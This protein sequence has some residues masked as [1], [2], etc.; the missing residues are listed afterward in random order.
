MTLQGI[1]AEIG[2]RLHGLAYAIEVCNECRLSCPTCPQGIGERYKEMM[3]VDMFMQVLERALSQSKIRELMLYKWGDPLLHPDLDTLCRE[4]VHRGVLTKLSTT[5]NNIDCDLKK[6][7]L[8]GVSTFFVSFSGWDHYGLGHRGGN[9]E[10]V[11][12]NIDYLCNLRRHPDTKIVMR[13]L[14]YKYNE[15]ELG[16]AA[17][18]CTERGI[19]FRP[20]NAFWAPVYK[21]IDGTIR[22]KDLAIIEQ[23]NESLG[24]KIKRLGNPDFCYCQSKTISIDAYGDV[25][26]CGAVGYAERFKVGHF[27]TMPLSDIRR[28]MKA[29]PYCIRCK[30]LGMSLYRQDGITERSF[31]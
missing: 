23:F 15:H 26:L 10:R 31:K 19:I 3:G 21:I 6:V 17:D 13:F 16:R 29:H 14:K 12:R 2:W 11:L 22:L 18:Y 25:Y 27:L 7:M 20:Y 5:M 24:E 4:A 8:T 30:S 1:K 28:A 9:L